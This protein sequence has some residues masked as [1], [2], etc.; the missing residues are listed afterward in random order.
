VVS[1]LKDGG[2]DV[3][4]IADLLPGTL[5]DHRQ[6]FRPAPPAIPATEGTKQ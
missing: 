1:V 3:D 5:R 6:E 2:W 4:G